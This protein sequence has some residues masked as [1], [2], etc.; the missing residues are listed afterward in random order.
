MLSKEAQLNMAST[1]HVLIHN[2]SLNEVPTYFQNVKSLVAVI[3]GSE[4]SMPCWPP[5]EIL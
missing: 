4:F 3:F 1:E 5:K 2:V